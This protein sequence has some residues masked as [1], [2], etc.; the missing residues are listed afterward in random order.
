MNFPSHIIL[1]DINHVYRA[2]IL[3]NKSLWL[4]PLY[5]A[6]AT[7]FYYEKVHRK[8]CTAIVSK[9]LQVAS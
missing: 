1:N 8:M 6:V 7:Y 2:A 4:L 3:K 5:M 9:L